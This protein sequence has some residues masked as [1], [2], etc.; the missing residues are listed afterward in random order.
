MLFFL[1]HIHQKSA[2]RNSEPDS[3][4]G[5]TCF[6]CIHISFNLVSNLSERFFLYL[7]SIIIINLLLLLSRNHLDY[8]LPI[9]DTLKISSIEWIIVWNRFCYIFQLRFMYVDCVHS[10]KKKETMAICK[11]IISLQDKTKQD[12]SCSTPL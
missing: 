4:K 2:T 5:L 9:D 8:T 12:T 10:I 7:Y 3:W 1:D 11:D 6:Y